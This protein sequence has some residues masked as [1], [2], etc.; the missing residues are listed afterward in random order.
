[1]RPRET[2]PLAWRGVQ[3]SVE[4]IRDWKIDGWSRLIIRAVRPHGAPLPFSETGFHIHD[5]DEDEL[6]RAGGVVAFVLAWCERDAVLP[7]YDQ[8]LYKYKQ[9]DL[10]R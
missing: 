1:M 3:C 6:V 7:R 8:A 4:H 5:L 10:F 9:G 2:F